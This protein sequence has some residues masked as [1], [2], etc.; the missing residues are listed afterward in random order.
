MTLCE[1]VKLF[2]FFPALSTYD[3]LFKNT[4]KQKKQLCD[5]VRY[6]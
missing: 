6:S 2:F 4:T 3:S 5:P 1:S